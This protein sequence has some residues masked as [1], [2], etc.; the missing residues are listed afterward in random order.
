MRRLWKRTELGTGHSA[1]WNDGAR[2]KCRPD[3]PT[4]LLESDDRA[5]AVMLWQALGD[6]GYRMEWCPGPDRGRT[7]RCSLTASGRCDAADQA[8]VVVS[9]LDFTC[10]AARDTVSALAQRPEGAPV[11][12]SAPT[13]IRARYPEVGEG[14]T[15][16][17][18]HLTSHRVVRAVQSAISNPSPGS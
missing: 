6:Q 5:E 15:V 3:R 18:D 12:V 16:I 17:P 1:G 11:L 14:T 4:V 7:R 13:Y 2:E 9:H 8:D 10:K